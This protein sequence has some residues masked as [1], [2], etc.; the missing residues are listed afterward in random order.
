MFDNQHHFKWN[1][2]EAHAWLRELEAMRRS[3]KAQNYRI[4]SAFKDEVNIDLHYPTPSYGP[5]DPFGQD[6]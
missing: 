2:S 6:D 1:P 5:L 4:E 3:P